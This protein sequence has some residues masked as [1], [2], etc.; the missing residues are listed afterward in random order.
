MGVRHF[1]RGGRHNNVEKNRVRR[2]LHIG[3]ES[4][5]GLA[6]PYG[7][8]GIECSWQVRYEVRYEVKKLARHWRR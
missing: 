4:D 1:S 5:V 3:N 8:T 7:E 2:R 6:W